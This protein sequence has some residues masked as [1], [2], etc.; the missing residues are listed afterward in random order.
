MIDL[1]SSIVSVLGQYMGELAEKFLIVELMRTNRKYT[2][3]ADNLPSRLPDM[4]V[5]TIPTTIDAEDLPILLGNLEEACGLIFGP[6]EAKQIISK[7]EFLTRKKG[8]G[9]PWI[10]KF[11]DFQIPDGNY[12]L[13]R[14]QIIYNRDT[15]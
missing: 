10:N 5:Q 2:P 3:L 14:Q 9:K 7:I 4:T 8:Q 12:S 1:Y 13:A 6:S 15:L 11:R